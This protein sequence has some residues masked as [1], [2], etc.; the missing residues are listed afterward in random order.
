MNSYCKL[1][2]TG[3]NTTNY[4]ARVNRRINWLVKQ[5]TWL[6]NPTPKPSSA[7]P[8]ISIATFCAKALI[9]APEQNRRPPTSMDNLLPNFLVT[10]EATKEANKAAMYNVEVNSVT[11]WLSNLQY[12][13][14]DVFSSSFLYT[15]GKKSLRND[16]IDV[17]PPYKK[18]IKQFIRINLILRHYED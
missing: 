6:A 18:Y 3:L 16:G 14:V 12:W 11:I 10:V 7:R 2:I 8:I 9:I 5:I 1:S 15:D 4:G 17:T 13:F